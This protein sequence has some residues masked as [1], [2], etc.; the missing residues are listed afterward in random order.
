MDKVTVKQKQDA[1]VCRVTANNNVL[2][3]PKPIIKD[4][5]NFVNRKLG[6]A[7]YV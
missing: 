7:K 6:R 1:L 4:S 2:N 5:K 3:I